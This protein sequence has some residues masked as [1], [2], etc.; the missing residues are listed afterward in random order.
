MLTSWYALLERT[1]TY[2]LSCSIFEQGWLGVINVGTLSKWR[3]LVLRDGMS[4][5]Q[6]SL[7]LGISRNSA[8]KWLSEPEMVEPQYPVRQAVP[9]VLEPYKE[10]LMTWLKADSHRNKFSVAAQFAHH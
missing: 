7:R 6:A 5:R 1:T 10:Q 9:S 4:V 8:T 2:D 3:R